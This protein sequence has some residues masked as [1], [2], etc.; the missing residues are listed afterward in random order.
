MVY[1]MI[2]FLFLLIVTSIFIL[3]QIEIYIIEKKIAA[4]KVEDKEEILEI[5]RTTT[6]QSKKWEI[7]RE[8][9]VREGFKNNYNV[10]I[11]PSFTEWDGSIEQINFTWEEILPF[12]VDY[13]E[14]GPANGY[15]VTVAKKLAFYYEQ[16]GELDKAKEVLY[17]TS[18]RFSSIENYNREELLVERIRLTKKHGQLEQ[19]VQYINELS[20]EL[21]SKYSD[22]Y[23]QVALFKTEILIQQGYTQEALVEIAEAIKSI[24]KDYEK[25]IAEWPELE[26]NSSL[27]D[28]VY[29]Q[30]LKTLERSL[31]TT[32]DNNP[33]K[34]VNVTGKVL[35]SDGSPMVGVGVFLRD[36]LNS[37]RSVLPEETY[38]VT[39]DH[40]GRYEFKG[41]TPNH[42]QLTLGFH[43]D[44][45]SGWSWP[46]EMNDWI[47]VD[48]SQDISYDIE[49]QKLI[50]LKSP[51]NQKVITDDSVYFQW[52]K[53]EEA[54]SYSLNLG[55]ERD[56]GTITLSY[57]TGIKENKIKVKAE[58]IYNISGSVAFGPKDARD[59]KSYLGFA[60][61]TNLL[62]WSVQAYD[63]EGN[64]ISQSNGYRLDDETTGNLPFFYLKERELTSIDRIL[65]NNKYEEALEK[66]IEAYERNPSDLHSLRMIIKLIGM[67]G[68]GT[69]ETRDNLTISYMKDLAVKTDYPSITFDVAHFYYNQSNWEEFNKWMDLYLEKDGELTDY[70]QSIYA[71]ALMMQGEYD[72]A[73]VQFN[74]AL[75]KDKSHRFVGYWIVNEL[76][77]NGL[78]E[79][80]IRIAREFPERTAYEST[81]NWLSLVQKMEEESALFDQYDQE[82]RMVLDNYFSNENK[83]LEKWRN[84][85]NMTAM[86]QFIKALD[87]VN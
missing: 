44:Q 82:L 19:A 42:Y 60:N 10:Y 45:I 43:T 68:D 80:V 55:Y 56:G 2:S 40:E 72:V 83:R 66:Y 49:L 14:N 76:L 63:G 85:T 22:T 81:P 23:A 39:T 18:K 25:E 26:E 5:L 57:K 9:M 15:L 3:P 77:R 64:I 69:T 84:T 20:S 65:L 51:V 50:E 67:E 70:I 61:P 1:I 31:T 29:Y 78:S 59:P 13:V 58:D 11:S 41:V 46:T 87:R 17:E 30:Q 71:S 52:E 38:Q 36:E 27:N 47:E 74:Q 35:K 37:S 12:L 79:E 21:N 53:V 62:H 24:E 32:R 6:V 7:I 8:Y 86:K 33:G 54:E 73:H 34:V 48:G 4:G 28:H 16:E 75:E